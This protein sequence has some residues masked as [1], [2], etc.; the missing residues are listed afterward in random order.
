[1]NDIAHKQA[2]QKVVSA[3]FRGNKHLISK[4]APIYPQSIEREFQRLTDAYMRLLMQTL[5]EHLPEIKAA[6]KREK[7]ATARHDDTSDLL[8][9]VQTAFTK[10]GVDLEQKTASFDLRQRIERMAHMTRKLTIKEWKRAVQATLGIDILD[11]YYLGEFYREAMNTWVDNNVGLIKT[12]PQESLGKMKSI[13]TEGYKS[14]KSTTVILK[15][16]QEAYG[17]DKRKARFL[18]RDQLAKLNGDLA[19][20]QQQDAGVK[21]YIWSTSGDTRVRD[22]HKRLNKKRFSWD[23]PPVVD[24]KTGRRC[25]PGEDYECRCVA[26]PVFDIESIDIPFSEE[27]GGAK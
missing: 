8:A 6:A 17:V 21:E 12:I 27:G 13:V 23:D 10:M 22:G 11:D 1:M 5:K 2:T 25:H 16:I 14:G 20:K 19:K 3:K 24:A 7:D 9:I 4:A 18:A 15:Q 26:L